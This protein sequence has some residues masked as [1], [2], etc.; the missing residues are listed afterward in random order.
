MAIF[1]LAVTVA[2]MLM[3]D[4]ET[5]VSAT[6]TLADGSTVKGDL[7]E[8]NLNGSALFADTLSLAPAIVRGVVFSGTNGEAKVTLSNGDIL[9]M[10]VANETFAMKS[11]IGDIKIKR[12]NL[13]SLTLLPTASS[14]EGLVFHCTFDDETS[15]RT[16]AIGPE[17]KMELGE[18]RGSHGKKGGALFV[19]P[20]VA[21]ASILFPAGTIGAEGCIE[22]WAKF[23][24]GKTEFSTGGDPR[25]FVLAKNRETELAHFQF[26]SNDG[27]GKSGLCAYFCGMSLA[28]NQGATFMMPYSDIFHGEDFNGWHHY[29]LSWTRTKVTIFLDGKALCSSSG[30]LAVSVIEESDMTMDIPLNREWGKSFNNKSAFLMDELKVWS[31]PKWEFD[32][33]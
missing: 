10:R 32:T 6:A 29:A 30:Q 28:S 8:K 15:V 18:L 31:Y 20:G 7:L 23:A 22:F 17:V 14:E 19:K 27:M 33:N 12:G 24:S 2:I 21:G 4:G 13:R 3:A 16:P 1:A 26:A 25:F 5:G 9:S 11:M